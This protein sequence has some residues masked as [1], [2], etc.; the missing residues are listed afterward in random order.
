MIIAPLG[1]ERVDVHEQGEQ[2][3]RLAEAWLVPVE[4][5]HD[6][7]LQ[8]AVREAALAALQQQLVRV[9]RED[10]VEH[11]APL[12]HV[13]E[14]ELAPQV[15]VR[16]HGRVVLLREHLVHGLAVLAPEVEALRLQPR[17]PLQPALHEL[18]QA[19]L[20]LRPG[21][22]VHGRGVVAEHGAVPLV[23][24]HSLL[25]FHSELVFQQPELQT[26]EARRWAQV[27]TE[28]HK[29]EGS[30]SFEDHDLVHQ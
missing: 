25:L 30:H 1:D 7:A 10:A 24:A 12:R 11:L 8:R 20:L 2:L 14:Q 27:V 29:I 23:E 22:G 9:G 21:D 16:G 4:G 17:G 26:L 18:R 5:D 3:V 19:R 28:V 15:R 6:G 13:V